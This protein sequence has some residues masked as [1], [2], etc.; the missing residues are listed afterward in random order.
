MIPTGKCHCG[1]GEDAPIATKTYSARGWVKGQPLRY[2]HNHDKRGHRVVERF[3]VEDR[4]YETPCHIWQL[5]T[6]PTGYGVEWDGETMRGAHVLAWEAVHGPVPAGLEL[7]H[8]CNVR[9]CRNVEHLEPVTH[10]ENL[11]RARAA[12]AA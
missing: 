1:C 9:P 11:R 3:T 5:A 10:A 12:A 6:L 2:I 8:K 7:D 4:G